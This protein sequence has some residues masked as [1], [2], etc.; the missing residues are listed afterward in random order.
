VL[1]VSSL[2][3]EAGVAAGRRRRWPAANGA[4]AAAMLFG[5]AFLAGQIGAWRQMSAAGLELPTGPH[6]AFFYLLTGVHGVHVV[7]ALVALAA[8]TARTFAGIG[9][10][11]PPSWMVMMDLVRT[12]WHFLLGLWVSV[13]TLLWML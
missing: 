8:A 10:R 6:A 4:L 5:M 9:R 3:L 11:D 12:F 2:A 1:V 13:F 7:A